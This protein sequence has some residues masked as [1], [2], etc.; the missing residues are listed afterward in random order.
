MRKPEA[1]TAVKLASDSSPSLESGGGELF[2]NLELL[3]L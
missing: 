3:N 2:L 1:K